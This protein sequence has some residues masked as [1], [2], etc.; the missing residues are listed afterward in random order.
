MPRAAHTPLEAGLFLRTS[1]DLNALADRLARM[2]A[3]APLGDPLRPEIV[4]VPTRGMGRWLSLRLA[5][6]TGVCAHTRFIFP[7]RLVTDVLR[8]L[9]PEADDPAPFDRDNLTWAVADLLR[10]DVGLAERPETAPIRQYIGGSELRLYQLAS[11]IADTFDQY[12]VYR[13]DFIRAWETGGRR[14]PGDADEAWQA[15]VWRALLERL[16]GGHRLRLQ[17]RLLACL[18]RG[19]RASVAALAERVSVF[20]LPTLPPYHLAV[21]AALARHVPVYIHLLTPSAEYWGDLRSERERRRLRGGRPADPELDRE[22]HLEARQPLLEAWGKTGRD[23]L[24][25]LLDLDAQAEELFP[26]RER[27]HLL[28]H[29]QADLE[30]LV[31]RGRG[32]NPEAAPLPV[33]PDD[34][35]IR[36][37]SCHSLMREAEVLH[38]HLLDCFA[39]LPDLA[40]GD[41]LVLA[42]DIETYAPYLRAVFDSVPPGRRIPYTITDRSPRRE[43]PVAEA[44]LTLLRLADSRFTAPDVLALLEFVP[45]RERFALTADDLERIRGWLV[46]ANIRWGLDGPSK[47]RL[48]LPP[49]PTHTWRAGLDRLLLG[50]ALP[51]E[52]DALF[53]G[54]APAAGVEGDGAAVLGRLAELVAAFGRLARTLDG[55]VTRREWARRLAVLLD[56]FFVRSEDVDRETECLRA[57]IHDLGELPGLGD[58]GPAYGLDAVRHSLEETLGQPAVEFGFLTGRVTCCSMVPM[59]SIPFRV[60]A[61]LGL[62]DAEFPRQAPECGFDLMRR[63]H[64]ILDRSRRDEDRYLFLESL[65]SARDVFYISYIGRHARDNSAL[66]PAVVVS[67][68]IDYIDQ[69]YRFPDA[70]RQQASGD[71]PPV[72]RLVVEHPLQPFSERYFT[73]PPGGALFTFSEAAAQAAGRGPAAAPAVPSRLPPAGP[74]WRV[75]TPGQLTEFFRNPAKF[76]LVNRL[77]ARFERE[78]AEPSGEEPFALD[79]LAKYCLKD[80]VLTGLAIGA[81]PGPTRARLQAAGELPPGTAGQVAF[82][83]LWR[84][85]VA[86]RE[87]VAQAQGDAETESMAVELALPGPDGPLTIRGAVGG[88][89]GGTLLRVRPGAIRAV[90]RLSLWVELLLLSAAHPD[91]VS[92]GVFIGMKKKD[93]DHWSIAPIPDPAA[94]LARLLEVFWEG[95]HG[96]I[97]FAPRSSEKF[98]AEFRKQGDTARAMRAAQDEWLGG[99]RKSP[100]ADDFCLRLALDRLGVFAS[101]GGGVHEEFARLALTVFEPLLDSGEETR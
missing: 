41:I 42:P 100:E 1:N 90:D 91:R 26:Q 77:Q 75:M 86:I 19:P 5:R 43:S 9:V 89:S 68:L 79:S 38:D 59:R 83:E 82:A 4:V 95:V 31:N 24:E 45:V 32:K 23:F 11:R 57:A 13:P 101:E 10:T 96:F 2:V 93:V 72:P 47:E 35:S 16:G 85:A 15:L 92:R 54:I 37:V 94:V 81:D 33:A 56:E 36:V 52:A 97:P 78:E 6:A 73:G 87:R 8:P 44:F 66:Q 88:V 67:Q 64:R 25:A 48:G 17:E 22:F 60:I 80:A 12:L 30:Q 74:E 55:S 28:G 61:L 84:E 49:E 98:A 34:R 58:E 46:G 27:R 65:L 63:E 39:T 29:L 7:N 53:G 40:P 71:E 14:L 69:G 70:G 62:N 51:P 76:L 50:Y 3:E 99:Y 21:L 18:E 20:G